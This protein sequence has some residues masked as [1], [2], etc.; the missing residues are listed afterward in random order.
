MCKLSYS[1]YAFDLAYKGHILKVY[2]HTV[3]MMGM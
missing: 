3:E 2:G 1:H